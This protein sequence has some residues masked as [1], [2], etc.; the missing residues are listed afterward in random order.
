MV[1][2]S[3][4]DARGGERLWNSPDGRV[5]RSPRAFAQIEPAI[6]YVRATPL[7]DQRGFGCRLVIVTGGGSLAG[8][9]LGTVGLVLVVPA[10]LAGIVLGGISAAVLGGFL[11]FVAGSF[12][13]VATRSFREA[14]GQEPL[15]TRPRG[16]VGLSFFARFFLR[17]SASTRCFLL[18]GPATRA[19]DSC[20]ACLRGPAITPRYHRLHPCSRENP[21]KLAKFTWPINSTN[22]RH[23]A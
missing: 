15:A 19:A 22:C 7:R 12:V 1:P 10:N 14:A 18:F 9:L 17:E 6:C 21:I 3:R 4:R 11:G 8:L 13:M 2:D 23:R 20:H 16:Q 5:Q